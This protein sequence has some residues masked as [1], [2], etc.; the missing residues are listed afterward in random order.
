VDPSGSDPA[1]LL[2]LAVESARTAG[3]L[4]ADRFARGGEQSVVSKSTPTDLASEADLAAERAIRDL[5]A[6]RRPGDQLLGEEG[7]GARGPLGPDEVRWVFD[8]LDGTINYLFR[9]P[10]WCVSVACEDA[11]G[12]LAGVVFDPLRDELFTATRDAG[13]LLN[14]DPVERAPSRPLAESLLA[15]GFG[16]D[17]AIRARQAAIVSGL[18]GHVRDVRRMGSAALDLAWL[19]AGRYDLYFE[20]GVKPWDVAAGTLLCRRAGLDVRDLPERD[21]LPPGVMAG[22]TELLDELARFDL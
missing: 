18:I 12:A 3:A 15:T 17:A 19:A 16:Y 22:R 2:D 10:Q 20:R 9:V 1:D 6:E 21:D 11:G 14:G 8:P 5:L 7:G 13:P 4:L